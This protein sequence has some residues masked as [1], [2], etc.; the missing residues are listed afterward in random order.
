MPHIYDDFR[1]I[2]ERIPDVV[3]VEFCHRS[4][5][6]T[7]TFGDLIR[8][9]E[10]A[11][12]TLAGLGL[13]PGERCAILAENH[14]R[15]FVAYLGI[16]RLGAVAVP[17]D[18]AYSAAQIRTLLLDSGAR[19]IVASPR[20]LEAARSAAETLTPAPHVVLHSGSAPGAV[21]LLPPDLPAAAVAR[22][23]C[24]RGRSGRDALHVGHHQR[25]ERRG[26]DARQSPGRAGGSLRRDQDRRTGCR[27]RH[28]AALPCA[29][30]DRQPAG[31]ADGRHAHRLSR[32]RE[33][34]RDDAGAQR[35]PDHGV[36][37]RPAVLLSAPPAHPRAG[38]VPRDGRRAPPSGRSSP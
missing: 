36:L 16:L 33:Q 6:D 8:L 7:T 28:P 24:H 22:L 2:A 3:A 15:W 1:S 25:S 32:D 31:P 19:A 14:A 4:G 10:R 26:P 37:R 30:A 38:R 13:A 12:S 11:A 9:A 17:L 20:Y 18:T 29:R 5:V 27:P 23:P 21:D 34:R 35:A